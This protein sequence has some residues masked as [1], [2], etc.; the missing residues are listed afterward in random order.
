V[1][2]K[3]L[4]P[5]ALT[6]LALSSCAKV[7]DMHDA[8]M[9]MNATTAKLSD[10]SADM[11]KIMTE[12]MD[13]GR[14]GASLDLRNKLWATIT[15]SKSLEEKATNAGLYFQ[16]FE[17]ELWNNEGMDKLGNQRQNLMY[18]AA[19]ELFCHL[20]DITHWDNVDPFAGKGL[21]AATST[22]NEQMTFN[23]IA[24]TL[25]EVNRKQLHINSVTNNKTSSM[26]DMIETSLRAGKSIREGN[27]QL[28]DYPA[29]VDMILANEK[30]A[31]KLIQ[32]RY[33]MLGL[34]VLTKLTPI[35]QNK[36]EGF[37][38]KI[39]G[40][41]WEIDFK[42]LNQSEIKAV[43][44]RLKQANQARDLLADLGDKEELNPSLKS[45]Y[46]HATLVNADPSL[47]KEG[48]KQSSTSLALQQNFSDA[49]DEY[50]GK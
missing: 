18:D 15:N 17:F 7:K 42:K 14:Q 50:R 39:W 31:V 10:T 46:G 20:L 16:A 36:M 37:K 30:N 24:D 32:A 6:L 33:H 21:F 9:Q 12:V 4:L 44:L 29:Y 8:T 23:A 28:S 45:I 5:I 48:L 47:D 38:Y 34:E 25:E 2:P 35:G 22:Q 11:A 40:S 43:T 27:S 19:K 49:L 13:T 26:L 41:A 3:N 1:A